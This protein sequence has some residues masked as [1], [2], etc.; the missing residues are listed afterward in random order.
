[1]GYE[2]YIVRLDDYTDGDEESK[3][4]LDEWLAYVATDKEL[5]SNVEVFW[6]LKKQ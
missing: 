3:I 2:L 1:M 5:S 4:S 6:V